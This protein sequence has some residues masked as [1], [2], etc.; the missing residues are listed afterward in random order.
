M[1][2]PPG[3][4]PPPSCGSGCKEAG[5]GPRPP[6]AHRPSS[7]LPL[8]PDACRL[9]EPVPSVWEG[10]A[11]AAGAARGNPVHSGGPA[12]AAQVGRRRRTSW[13]ARGQSAGQLGL[14]RGGARW[15]LEGGAGVSGPPAPRPVGPQKQRVMLGGLRTCWVSPPAGRQSPAR[16]PCPR[17]RLQSRLQVSELQ[18]L[19]LS[20]PQSPNVWTGVDSSAP[21]AGGRSVTRPALLPCDSPKGAQRCFSPFGTSSIVMLCRAK[22]NGDSTP[23]KSGGGT[24]SP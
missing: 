23:C 22:G 17:A 21:G 18:N 9:R 8:L 7:P 16:Q 13:G 3:W 2:F 24:W 10:G 6:P 5:R 20:G 4:A 15:K 11:A 14:V 1:E 19:G 12:G